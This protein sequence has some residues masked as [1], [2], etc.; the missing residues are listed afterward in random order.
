MNAWIRT[1]RFSFNLLFGQ[2]TWSLSFLTS[3]LEI[4]IRTSRGSQ[5]ETREHE[6]VLWGLWSVLQ[7]WCVVKPCL[8]SQI[9]A[10]SRPGPMSGR[11]PRTGGN[12]SSLSDKWGE[13]SRVARRTWARC[14]PPMALRVQEGLLRL[15]DC[16]LPLACLMVWHQQSQYTQYTVYSVSWIYTYFCKDVCIFTWGRLSYLP[17]WGGGKC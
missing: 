6:P 17:E 2:V 16:S 9:A 11:L 8:P 13:V 7:T 3:R 5:D 12:F 1:P 10:G 15:M 14:G 4:P